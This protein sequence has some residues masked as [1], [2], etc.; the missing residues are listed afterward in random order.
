L[1]KNS[2]SSDQ[3][4]I[5]ANQ[6][7]KEKEFWFKQLAGELERSHFPYDHLER[8]G[9]PST[10]VIEFE[11]SR[12][13]FER[14]MKLTRGDAHTLH[15]IL[16]TGLVLL[17]H[18]YNGHN[19]IIVGS[20]IDRQEIRGQ[21]I[22]RVLILRNQIRK[23]MTF[24][25]FL[26]GVRQTIKEAITNYKYPLEILYEQLKLTITGNESP[27]FSTAILLQ[28]I[29]DR[30]YIQHIKLDIVFYFSM[31][32]DYIN[33]Q[34][35]YDVS[36]Y[37]RTTVKRIINH[38]KY[39]L[40]KA[41]VNVDIE[42]RE[43][44]LLS[45][46]EKRQ[47]L[48]EFNDTRAEY[49]GDKT[50]RQIFTRQVERTPD[51]AALVGKEE[52]WK[53]RRI[54]GKKENAF[55]EM[56]L[57]YNELNRKSDQLAY[58]LKEKG[59]Q[60]D[61]IVGIMME[62]S[63][64]MIFGILGILKAGAA[65]MPIAPDYPV[66]RVQYMFTDSAS[67]IL[68]TTRDWDYSNEIKFEKEI[69]Y[70]SDAINCAPTPRPLSFY[71]ST[72]SPYPHLSPASVTCLTYV[73]YTSGSSGKSRGVL[74]EQRNVVNV[75]SWFAGKYISGNER[76]W[77]VLLMSDYTFDPSVNQILGTLLH[78]A[79]LYMV[80]KEML[81]DIPFMRRYIDR[82]RIHLL[83][84]VPLMLNDLLTCDR[85]LDSIRFVLSGGEQ[86]TDSVKEN[87]IKRGY[88]LYNQYG[89]T[90]TTID[91][92]VEQCGPGK[93][94]L[95]YPISNVRCYILNK[96]KSLVPV[97][98]I[99]EL[100]VGGDGVSRGYLNNPELAAEKFDHDLW[101]VRDYP[102]ERNKSFCGGV[103]EFHG[104]LFSKRAPL[105]AEGKIYKTGDLA[106]W[107]PDGK[108]EFFGRIDNQVKIRGFRI[109]L[110]E[111][112]NDLMRHDQIKE[113]V[114]LAKENENGDKYLAAYIVPSRE[115]SEPVT[116]LRDY[117]SGVLPDYMIPSCFMQIEKIPMTPNGKIDRKALPDPGLKREKEYISP[118]NEREEILTGL[119]SEILGI[120]R[121]L[122]G[123]DD[124]F[125]QLGGH[126]LSAMMMA[127]KIHKV[128][129]VKVSLADVFNF[130]TIRG[131]SGCI[132]RT[133]KE[134][135]VSMAPVEKKE[136][137]ALS[138][139][140]KRLYVLRQMDLNDTS[141]NMPHAMIVKGDLKVDALERVIKKII[142]RHESLR[143]FFEIVDGE[144]VQRVHD[145]VNLKLASRHT[146]V[147]GK[148]GAR[149][150]IKSFDRTFSKIWPPRQ[151]LPE[152]S[153]QSM[154]EET[155][156]YLEIN[157]DQVEAEERAVAHLSSGFIRPFELSHAPLLRVGLIKLLHTAPTMR[158]HRRQGAYNSQE[159]KEDRYLLMV[160]MHH[161]ISD[162]ISI[163]N[164]IKEFIKIYTK[165]PLF[166]LRVQYKDY[167]RWQNSKRVSEELKS[168]E[169][170]WIGQFGDELPMGDLPYDFPRPVKW[171]KE[172]R[173]LNFQLGKKETKVL[174][175]W[176]LKE[177]TTLYVV[178][179]TLF[180]IF[181]YKLTGQ[182]D[183]IIGTPIAGRRHEDFFPI[184][185][186]FVNTLALRN[187]PQGKK[188][189]P[190]FLKEVKTNTL[191][192]YENQDYQ[193]E[194]LVDRLS[195]DRNTGRNPLFDVML[196]FQEGGIPGLQIPGLKMAPY[197]SENKVSKFDLTL[198]IEERTG[199]FQCGFEYSTNLFKSSTIQ[200][201]AAY[202]N[203]IAASLVM[204]P[205]IEP[206][207]I[208][209]ITRDEKKQI[210]LQFNGAARGFP[211]D[212]T[213]M[214]LFLEQVEQTPHRIALISSGNRSRLSY[215]ELNEKSLQLARV[216]KEKGVGP[217]VIVG[218]MVERSIEM[219]IG[220]YGILKAGGTYMPL[221]PDYPR[222]RIRYM[223]EESGSR[224][225]IT[226]EQYLTS[227]D[228]TGEILDLQ[229]ESLF[230]YLSGR[231]VV[232]GR[233]TSPENL[234]YVIYTSGS[235][236]KPRGVPIKTKAFVNLVDWYIKEF[237]LDARDRFLLIAP[238]SFDLTQKN[239][240]APLFIG[241]C[242]CL[243]PPGLREYDEL[244]DFIVL[245]QQTVINCAPCVFYP[246]ASCSGHDEFKRLQSLRY[247][248]LGG[249]PIWMDQ[250]MSW[251]ESGNC[252]CNI[253]NT[254]G[255]TECTD[256]VSFYPVPIPVDKKSR[257]RDIP[258]GGPVDNV[259]L[260]VL[261]NRQNLLPV[262]LSGEVCIG[263]IGVS[264]GYLNNP[265]LTAEKF[266]LRRPGGS[267]CKNRPLDPRKNFLLITSPRSSHST[268]YKTGDLGRWLE[269]GDIEF[270]GRIDNQV[271]IRGLRI[272]LGEIENQLLKHEIVK[273]TA[274]VAIADETRGNYLCGYIVPYSPGIL[275]ASVVSQ[276]KE[277]LARYLPGYMIP[278]YFV[279]LEKLPLTPSG[280]IHR[281][282]LPE[283][284]IIA[285]GSHI[286]A[287]RNTIEKKLALIWTG[288]LSITSS[289]VSIDANFFEIGGHSL[290][291][292]QLLNAI[293]K[294][295]NV[296]IKFQDIFQYPT[297]AQLSGLIRQS[298]PT[299]EYEIQPQPEKEYY[300]LS[301]SQW[302]LM[303]LYQLDPDSPAFNLPVRL[304]LY[305]PM[306]ETIVVKVLEKLVKRHAG[307]RTYFKSHQGE[308]VQIIRSHLPVNPG[309][310]DLSHL[311][312]PELESS[313]QQLFR[314]ES[315]LPF[316][317]GL[318]PL[319][320]VKLIKCREEEFDL[321]L[322]MHH[323]IT[324]GWSLEILEHEFMVLYESYKKGEGY[325]PGPLKIRYIDYVN[326]H[327]RL[328]RDKEKMRQA[329]EFW[330]RRLDGN[331][332]ILELPYD[333]SKKN[334]ETKQSA[335]YRTV[336]PDKTARGLKKVAEAGNASLFMVL[337]AGYNIMLS[338]IT[339]Q[340]DILLAVPGA[341]RQHED[342]KNIVGMFVNTLI[343]RNRPNPGDTFIAFLENLQV[344]TLQV[345]DHQSYPLELLCSEFNVT[346]PE[347]PVFFN[348]SA[349]GRT[350]E[351]N[352]KDFSSYHTPRVQQAKFDI[353]SYI[354]EYKN[355]IEIDTHYYKELF[356]PMTIEKTMKMYLLALENIAKDP[357]K[358]IGAY[359]LMARKRKLKFSN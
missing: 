185:G 117:L 239:L 162:G 60:S 116:G 218:L 197:S 20:P 157:I 297:I 6:N 313:R 202:F 277:H 272:E 103:Q 140:Q 255:P 27:L 351:E 318:P 176:A 251:L 10:D 243:P 129:G 137:Y 213:L 127:A 108:L 151:G 229:D 249:E 104:A 147:D 210:L 208:V 305:D 17:L 114:V 87:I 126:S 136:Y 236:G 174:K 357:G 55:S 183:I 215:K 348:M 304:T 344:N 179:L 93:V 149:R 335:A 78:G 167:A 154:V 241:G 252:R 246:F 51:C 244:S 132:N 84:S 54:E 307:F 43:I 198:Y 139:A 194:E 310:R 131:L 62:R 293:Q 164:F 181:L 259:T 258:I 91:V 330:K 15:L 182:E 349:F 263:G 120:E 70:I 356:K 34:V 29:H 214:H 354:V 267:F 358:K 145:H 247:V 50:V 138:S 48:E 343:V 265:E 283:P 184:I 287:P 18:K 230:S 206:G 57:S 150:A 336:I 262:G 296:K 26:L 203:Q 352:L 314:Q 317:L 228:F 193:F 44:N 86:L 39:L 274:V 189:F 135:Y 121:H 75:V 235:T 95:G 155:L 308:P 298:N 261:D 81:F 7:I 146:S 11:F 302:R 46:E 279:E 100:Y 133:L 8:A 73:I 271:K 25:Q 248:F 250:L 23:S 266:C 49:P 109:E 256:V 342:L 21:F 333:Y 82:H 74:V 45:V 312:D 77:H 199:I 9:G 327:N 216:L 278:G 2:I 226:R 142:A 71:P 225:L 350:H 36:F 61:T 231:D 275:N 169:E 257:P 294:E 56:Y 42:I 40:V 13:L 276:L 323:I 80:S 33:G 232:P 63:F 64:E 204:N 334:L 30:T 306:A 299:V 268:I 38:F 124:N 196:V 286:I 111:I 289:R 156:E 148:T 115:V 32:K 217:N 329:K 319:F 353:V 110:G 152:A 37:E 220:L 284:E 326:W 101:D 83:N 338:R 200:R 5:A 223:L 237:D 19:D 172:G 113:A 16:V 347:V 178:L 118:R 324:D 320:R 12:E 170:Y 195:I 72:H 273:E 125:F 311:N 177:N 24:K 59:V 288:I 212:K 192:A 67:K 123:I 102:N 85:K 270:L 211:R 165:K 122:I 65:Y 160:D 309:V 4:I 130:L 31:Q 238:I 168:Q 332:P 143:T 153:R 106:R 41:L 79:I 119:W 90:E 128:F 173:C 92:S 260:Y 3:L 158:G 341:A 254:Y 291:A 98:V 242:L 205:G 300:A 171:S 69:I 227:I 322:T 1:K 340:Q 66:Q 161:I 301:Y 315:L 303:V 99:G 222:E 201:F 107:L 166:P 253:V 219:M 187:Y 240:F 264:P 35:E 89:P 58:V 76:P 209:I 191:K 345:L 112:E 14:L 325:E 282:A 68:L 290:N 328:I 224:I 52:G 221:A 346:Y 53:G 339:G 234:V 97:G 186:M 331:Y 134:S 141:Y 245:E 144:P 355:G 321:I 28:N 175:L 180:N 292:L 22:N 269:E 281:K 233:K 163:E 88:R 105:V 94:T 159:G 96:H 295:F 280:K 188:P 285:P 190:V 207:D 47:L 337:L 359:N 316:N